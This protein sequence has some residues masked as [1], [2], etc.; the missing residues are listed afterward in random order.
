MSVFDGR[1]ERKGLVEIVGLARPQIVVIVK[2]A[3]FRRDFSDLPSLQIVL[4]VQ[5]L[6]GQNKS[7]GI[8]SNGKMASIGILSP[9]KTIDSLVFIL[10]NKNKRTTQT[11]KEEQQRQEEQQQ[12]EKEQ[13]QQREE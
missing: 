1:V 11:K 12:R 3:N 7:N 2:L 6:E 5:N 10:V 13:Q 9:T 4:L 8:M